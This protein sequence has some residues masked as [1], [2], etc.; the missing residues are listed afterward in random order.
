[1]SRIKEMTMEW[2][3]IR[4]KQPSDNTMIIRLEGPSENSLGDFN[5]RYAIWMCHY[6]AYISWEEQLKFNDET[7]WPIPHFWWIYAKDFP[8]PGDRN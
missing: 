8:F 3:Y 5:K 4:D 6:R 7:G 2:N 1:M